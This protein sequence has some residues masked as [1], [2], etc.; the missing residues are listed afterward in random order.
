MKS[1][2][3]ITLSCKELTVGASGKVIIKA[4]GHIYF[5][6]KSDVVLKGSKIQQN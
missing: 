4:I 1:D 5:Q 3:T 6:S 2:G